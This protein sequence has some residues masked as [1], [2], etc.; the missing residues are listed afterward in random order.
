LDESIIVNT[1][2]VSCDGGGPADGHPKVYLF[3]ADESID[4][5]YC[6]KVFILKEEERS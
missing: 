6:G 4:C 3:I 5:P 2:E 1:R